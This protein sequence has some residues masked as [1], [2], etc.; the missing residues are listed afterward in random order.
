MPEYYELYIALDKKWDYIRWR[1]NGARSDEEEELL[2]EMDTVWAWASQQGVHTVATSAKG[3]QSYW[4]ASYPL[5]LLLL[6]GSEHLG[7]SQETID[8][9]DQLVTIPM[10]GTMS[11]LNVAVAAGLLLYEVARP[12]AT[13]H[14]RRQN[15]DTE[16][17]Q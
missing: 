12:P 11:S 1:N 15:V 9:A 3:G 7:L 14:D 16:S 13:S 8:T 6:L 17:S 4:Q 10:R 2:A 5:P